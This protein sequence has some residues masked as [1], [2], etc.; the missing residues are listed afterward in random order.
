M[1]VIS[2]LVSAGVLSERIYGRKTEADDTTPADAAKIDAGAPQVLPGSDSEKKAEAAATPS[3]ADDEA[4]DL[5]P[6]A[7]AV[8]APGP[9]VDIAV[10]FMLMSLTSTRGMADALDDMID[11]LVARYGDKAIP[12]LNDVV[13]KIRS[14]HEMLTGLVEA[15]DAAD[16]GDTADDADPDA[17]EAEGEGGEEAAPEAQ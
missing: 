17:P 10:T 5:D 13:F 14:A 8:P 2:D 15:G 3:E 16:E 12:V 6:G 11:D 4:A 1:S 9:G 7:E